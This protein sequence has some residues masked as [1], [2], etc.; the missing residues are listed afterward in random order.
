MRLPPRPLAKTAEPHRGLLPTRGVRVPRKRRVEPQGVRSCS[1]ETLTA[2]SAPEQGALVTALFPAG[3]SELSQKCLEPARQHRFSG[4]LVAK[5]KPSAALALK[6]NEASCSAVLG[7]RARAQQPAAALPPW[8]RRRCRDRPPRPGCLEAVARFR[9]K[10]ISTP[11]THPDRRSRN[12]QIRRR[13][14]ATVLRRVDSQGGPPSTSPSR[15]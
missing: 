13:R 14:V 7:P 8:T 9:V 12:R 4:R 1:T 5:H 15:M 2:N 3:S 10:H 11:G 6:R